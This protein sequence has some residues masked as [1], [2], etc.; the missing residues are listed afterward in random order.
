MTKITKKKMTKMGRVM[1]TKM[2]TTIMI[3]KQKDKEQ[4][5]SLLCS[6]KI[7]YSSLKTSLM[8]AEFTDVIR[9]FCCYSMVEATTTAPIE[10]SNFLWTSSFCSLW[11]TS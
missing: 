11:R 4:D 1:M 7:Q 8:I 10:E 6:H 2:M 9:K 5:N 3:I